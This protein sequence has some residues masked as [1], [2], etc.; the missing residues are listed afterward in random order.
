VPSRLLDLP[1]S[2]VDSS[3]CLSVYVSVAARF[4]RRFPY[5]R[6]KCDATLV[7]NQKEQARDKRRDT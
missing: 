1:V 3:I 7:A 4:P 2:T 5:E 6:R